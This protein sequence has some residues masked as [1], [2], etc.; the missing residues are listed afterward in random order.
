M[1]EGRRDDNTAAK[2]LGDEK[3]PRGDADAAVTGG[4]DGK[5]RTDEGT[6]ENHENGGDAQTHAAI[7]IVACLAGVGAG[8]KVGEV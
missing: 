5:C 1:N 3:G 7:V 4:E 8:E 6:D 2:E